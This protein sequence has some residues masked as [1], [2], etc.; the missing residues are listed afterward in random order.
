MKRLNA[1]LGTFFV[2]ALS[3]SGQVQNL[4]PNWSF[5]EYVNCCD[6]CLTASHQYSFDEVLYWYPKD[7]YAPPVAS[8]IPNYSSQVYNYGTPDHFNPCT[9]SAFSAPLNAV[10]Y[11]QAYDGVMYVGVG[12]GSL[13]DSNNFLRESIRIELLSTLEAGK[14]Y[15]AE[16]HWA[17]WNLLN[18]RTNN[19]GMLFSNDSSYIGAFGTDPTNLYFFNP[20]IYENNIMYD[21]LNWNLLSGTFIANG[22]EKWLTIG[23]FFPPGDYN[24]I[25]ISPF[26]GI[27]YYYIDAVNVYQCDPVFE[28]EIVLPQFIS[29]N[30]DG[31]NDVY[32]INDSLPQG[33][34]LTIFNRWGNEV[35]H[36]NNYQNDWGGTYMGHLLPASTYYAVL[37]MPKGT[38][39]TTYIEL[40]Y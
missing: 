6:S 40:Q 5:E 28:E 22:D 16:L 7:L 26:P 30:G 3:L 35:Y 24:T 9:D 27:Y 12:A 33:S 34:K 36:S 32:F 8:G 17:S 23:W 39:K 1:I 4:V 15:C 18:S 13:N 2:P 29:P 25:D 10:G 38:R 31:K 11:Q 37:L 14:Q 20:Q 21:T 19:L